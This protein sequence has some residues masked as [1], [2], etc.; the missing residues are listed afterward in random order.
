MV[1]KVLGTIGSRL[2]TAAISLGV[3]IITSKQLG[4]EAVGTISLIIL[5]I[6][7]VQMVNSFIGGPSLVY[8]TPRIDIYKLFV[9]SY[10]WAV[11]TAIICTFL[12]KFLN[13]IPSEYFLH[14]L[15]L[16]LIQSLASVNQSILL[17]KE[18]IKIYNIITSVQV[19]ILIAVLGIFVFYLERKNVMSYIIALYTS[20]SFGML[21]SMIA[22]LKLLKVTD[23]KN[24]KQVIKTILH[25]GTYAQVANIVQLFNYRV[26]YYMIESFIGRASLGVYSVG[27]QL[28]EGLWL[29]GKSMAIVQYSRISNIENKEYAKKITLVFGKIS[30]LVTFVL[31]LILLLIPYQ[32]FSGIFGKDFKEL[33]IVILSLSSGILFL[34]FSF[35]L[36][37]YFSGMGK[38][39]HNTIS[40]SIGF[41]VTLVLG[42]ILIP[43]FHLWGAGITT[44]FAYLAILCYQ[45]IFFTKVSGAKL[46]ELLISSSDLKTFTVEIKN[47]LRKR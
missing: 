10:I 20:Y 28:S 14:V 40:S 24:F 30:L 11:I 29:T 35:S 2:L 16:S 31:L 21:A 18:K 39:H 42:Y 12:L 17:G 45:I 1:N 41:V 15:M 25:Y 8:L 43:K 4:A 7:I 22:T 27:V 34:S 6:T 13:L 47:W 9:P 46:K 19:V 23:L 38:P 3:I 33:P 36:S 37:H 44:S 5:G 32:F 26:T